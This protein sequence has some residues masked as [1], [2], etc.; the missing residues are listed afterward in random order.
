VT[1]ATANPVMLDTTIANLILKFFVENSR[2]GNWQETLKTVLADSTEAA[3]LDTTIARIEELVSL[4]NRSAPVGVFVG[5]TV[6]A[7]DELG[8][9]E[10][11]TATVKALKEHGRL[12]QVGRGRGKAVVIIDDTPFPS[13]SS[14]SIHEALPMAQVQ[15][16]NDGDNSN[17]AELLDRLRD[18]FAEQ[19]E[20]LDRSTAISSELRQDL[21]AANNKIN[22][23]YARLEATVS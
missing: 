4:A 3:S 19:Q 10:V 14:P 15:R 12:F 5:S 1:V 21:E 8:D 22:D 13:T 9:G 20:Q 16:S 17:V 2:R 6:A 11:T 7:K 18:M 23:L